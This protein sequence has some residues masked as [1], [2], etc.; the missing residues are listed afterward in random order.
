M[1]ITFKAAFN[2]LLFLFLKQKGVITKNTSA[3]FLEKVSICMCKINTHKRE[4]NY[5]SC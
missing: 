4:L 5:V 1:K 2:K 3:I